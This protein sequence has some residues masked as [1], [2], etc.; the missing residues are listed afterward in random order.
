MTQNTVKFS[1]LPDSIRIKLSDSGKKE[2][3]HRIDEFGGIKNFCE[4]FE[5]SS[6]TVYNWKNKDSFIPVEL[7]RSVFGIEAAEDVVAIKGE[8]RSRP[9]SKPDFPLVVD[10]ELLTRVKCS[11]NV[12]SNG[13][14]VYQSSD[15]GNV[16]RFAELLRQIGN[17][18]FEIYS[19]S[20]YELRYPKY[21]HQILS[22]INFGEDF[23]ALIDEEG[24]I[25]NGKLVIENREV[26]VE[27]F[28][29]ELHSRQKKYEFYLEIGDS[30][31]LGE[32]ISEEASRIESI[33]Q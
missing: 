19:R 18:P 33:I 4:A 16:R 9:I 20:V 22:E 3:W 8:G 21:L 11:V 29:G 13:I 15:Q 32:L 26:P 25:N 12:N 27:D 17:V 14:P 6:S 31:R 24:E 28:E 2:F 30:E 23:G 7:I 1:E 10:N 5:Y